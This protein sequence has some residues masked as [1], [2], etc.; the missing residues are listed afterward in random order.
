MH[1]LQYSKWISP[2]LIAFLPRVFTLCVCGIGRNRQIE[3]LM[4]LFPLGFRFF[5]PTVQYVL[6]RAEVSCR[7]CRNYTTTCHTKRDISENAYSVLS[8]DI[9]SSRKNGN[10]RELYWIV[11]QE[12]C[13]NMSVRKLNNEKTFLSVQCFRLLFTEGIAKVRQRCMTP[14][15]LFWTLE[16]QSCLAN[17]VEEERGLPIQTQT[18]KKP[19]PPT[20]DLACTTKT[21]WAPLW[22]KLIHHPV[23]C[24]VVIFNI[25]IGRCF[26]KI[27]VL[28]MNNVVYRSSF[29]GSFTSRICDTIPEMVAP[30][31]W[32]FE[33]RFGL[34]PKV[35]TEDGRWTNMSF[36]L[37]Y[38][39]KEWVLWEGGDD[40]V[41]TLE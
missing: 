33:K 32:C 18:H 10:K 2:H 35:G 31:F 26:Q 1:L 40:T 11:S 12:L 39:E 27:Q 41:V 24:Y 34:G 20:L 15:D 37:R 28:E 4:I 36:R 7:K 13:V 21:E 29:E 23:L 9:S 6:L 17:R 25:L 14:K 5:S 22:R 30:L 16:Q 38:S 19:L 3:W 8:G